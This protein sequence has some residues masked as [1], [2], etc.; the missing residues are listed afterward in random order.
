M[1]DRYGFDTPFMERGGIYGRSRKY[2]WTACRIRRVFKV[3]RCRDHRFDASERW[4]TLNT[5]AFNA[6]RMHPLFAYEWRPKPWRGVPG[7]GGEYRE[8][9]VPISLGEPSLV[10]MD[11][12]ITLPK[13]A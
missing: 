8:T 11:F 5:K 4:A 13:A 1:Y 2:P 10:L 3:I 7:G 6:D 12:K 9:P